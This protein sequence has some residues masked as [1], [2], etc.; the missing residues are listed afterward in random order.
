MPFNP[1]EFLAQ[2][3]PAPE[4]TQQPG[5]FDPDAFL[6][7]GQTEAE[8]ASAAQAHDVAQEQK[9]GSGKQQAIAAAEAIGQGLTGPIAPYVEKKLGVDPEDIRGREEANP[10][11]HAA[12]EIGGL[13]SPVGEGALLAKAGAKAATKLLGREVVEQGI[14]AGVKRGAV[15]VATENALYQSGDEISKMVKE[16]PNQSVQTAMTNVGLAAVLGGAAGGALGSVNPLWKASVGNK[17]GQFAADF[18]GRINEHL[19]NP[20]PVG[21]FTDELGQYH[22]NIKSMADEVYGPNGLKST[23]IKKLLPEVT[24]A[25]VNSSEKISS[26]LKETLQTMLDNPNDYPQPLINKLNSKIKAFDQAITTTRDPLTAEAVYK[27]T[28]ENLF[29]AAQDLKQQLQEWG[30]FN[31]NFVPLAEVDFRN[32]SKGMAHELRTFLEDPNTWG[33]AAERQQQ[34]NKAFSEYLPSL[35]DFE[36]KFTSEVGGERVI[37]PGKAA[38]YMNQLGKSSAELKQSMLENFINASEKYKQVIADTHSNLGLENPIPQSSLN[39]IK[40]TLKDLPTGAKLADV[41]VKKVAD[42]LGGTLIGGVLGKLSGVPFG[43]LGGAYLGEKFLGSILPSIA[44]PMLEKVASG[45]GL[46]AARTYGEAITKGAELSDRAIKSIFK[47]GKVLPE[48]KEPNRDTREKLEK[49]LSALQ[50]DSSRLANISGH[51]GHYLPDHA[52]SLGATTSNIVQFLNSI[53]P[54]TTPRA[55]LDPPT[56]ISKPIEG[57]YNRAL[58]IAQQPLVVLQSLKDGTLTS[59]DV[60]AMQNMYPG[61]YEGLKQKLMNEIVEVRSRDESIPYKTK[62]GLSLFMAQPLDSTMSPLGIMGAQPQQ[63]QLGPQSPESASN[64][65]KKVSQAAGSNLIKGAK[66]MQTQAQA[67]EAMH[68]VG[69]A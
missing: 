64:G 33:K 46:E 47:A 16:D 36:K 52:T 26:K 8:K 62:L 9:Y 17:A 7:A 63:S 2:S 57:Q 37:D 59:H 69:K 67:S 18:K 56:K 34:I 48:N 28:A 20:D 35:K 51:M 32:S 68:S 38:T 41:F 30:K 49:Q 31:K 60:V 53:K 54:Q 27:P 5:V 1:D 50:K 66:S 55:P 13:L 23:E 21:A 39:H 40:A 15:K 3:T 11:T 43:E 25:I 22:T 12:G 58:D 24:P 14:M 44:K 42:K 4:Q 6:A 65:P 10:I 61:L 45:E 19:T 29:N